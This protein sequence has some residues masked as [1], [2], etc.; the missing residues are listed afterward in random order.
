M[1]L[2]YNSSEF[3]TSLE[4]NNLLGSNLNLLTGSGVNT[5]TSGTFAYGESSET[6]KGNF[7]IC[8]HSVRNSGNSS[9]ESLLCIYFAETCTGSNST[10]EFTFVHVCRI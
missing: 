3:S 9:V 5:R 4:F 7:I 2:F 6:D 10:Y 8:L 1:S